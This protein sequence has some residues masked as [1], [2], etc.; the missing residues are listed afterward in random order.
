MTLAAVEILDRG[1]VTRHAVDLSDGTESTRPGRSAAVVLRGSRSS[2]PGAL[3]RAPSRH[4]S[5]SIGIGEDWFAGPLI[6]PSAG[7]P[8][9][10]DCV[11][12]V[13]VALVSQ[14][15][16]DCSLRLEFSSA[17]ARVMDYD[18]SPGAD[19]TV[20][21]RFGVVSGYFAGVREIGDVLE[22]GGAIDGHFAF[23]SALNGCL[24]V[25][26]SDATVLAVKGLAMLDTFT[27]LILA[28]MPH[29]HLRYQ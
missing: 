5:L 29:S 28:R 7:L 18:S 14:L 10:G 13:R 20:I 4:S 3:L 8:E 26:P 25:R 23:M 9:L 27:P 15:F 24:D 19:L 1:H 17:G 11:F 16:G 2:T 12:D 21:G 6:L 22:D